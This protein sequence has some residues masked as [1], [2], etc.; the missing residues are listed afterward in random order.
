MNPKYQVA[1]TVQTDLDQHFETDEEIRSAIRE[2]LREW[3]FLSYIK[4][5]RINIKRIEEQ[6]GEEPQ[7]NR[8]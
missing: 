7:G 6:P 3:E 2:S 1:F 4:I 8:D 5:G